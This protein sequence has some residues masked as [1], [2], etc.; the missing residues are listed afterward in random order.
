MLS[1]FFLLWKIIIE[2]K[3]KPLLEPLTCT[4]LLSNWN[5]PRYSLA[6]PAPIDKTLVKIKFRDNLSTEVEQKNNFNDP[7]APKER[8][9]D[10]DSM[11]T[12]KS[13]YLPL[14]FLFDDIQP[15]CSKNNEK[16]GIECKVVNLILY[17]KKIMTL[18]LM[19]QSIISICLLINF[20]IFHKILFK[21]CFTNTFQIFH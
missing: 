6:N 16:D 8:H 3:L 4:P 15:K 11:K 7:R 1:I 9:L 17:M 5:V 20:M 21:I 14:D 18:T 19:K 2:K 10:I 13:V 12:L